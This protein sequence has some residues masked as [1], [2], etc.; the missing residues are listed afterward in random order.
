MRSYLDKL[1]PAAATARTGEEI[2]LPTKL[3]G[4]LTAAFIGSSSLTAFTTA[5]AGAATIPAAATTGT[6][7]G[8]VMTAKKVLKPERSDI[9]V[10]NSAEY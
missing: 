10:K 8:E 5:T 1:C 9:L 6:Q 7:M 3:L 2:K 4:K